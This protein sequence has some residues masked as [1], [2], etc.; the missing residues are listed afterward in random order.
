MT[1]TQPTPAERAAALE[2]PRGCTF[3]ESD[4][5]ILADY[6]HPVAFS[7]DVGTAPVAARLL[8]VDL[9]VYRTTAG[10][11]VA[12]DLCLHRGSQLTRGRLEGDEIVCAY[13]GW[14]YGPEGRCTRIPSQPA[15]RRISPKIRL[16]TY[17]AVERYG[18]VWACLSGRPKRDLPDWPEAE[19]PGYRWLGLK[20]LDWATSAARQVDNFLDVSH[21]SFVHAQTFG[22]ASEPEIPEIPVR[23]TDYGLAYDF[24]FTANNPDAS[25]MEGGRQLVWETSYYVTLPFAVRLWE[26]FP[27]KEPGSIHMV[28]NVAAPVSAKRTRAF[29]FVC[30]NFDFDVPAEEI[31]EWEGRIMGEDQV[32]VEGQRPE[33]LPLDLTEEYH[34]QADRMTIAYRR[35]LAELGL[36]A[37]YSA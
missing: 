9:V 12:R 35:Q 3:T 20:P 1:T 8:D 24:S 21:F 31:L 26:A 5:R 14:R 13:H 18:L 15:A 34:V 23:L 25:P 17:Q 32:I 37:D 29:F 16:V 10:V 4:W 36:G 22:N 11:V 28:F 6:W 2:L 19:D 33:E 27:D 7:H 30:R